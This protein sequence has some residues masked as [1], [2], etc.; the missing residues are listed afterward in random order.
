MVIPQ[1]LLL[2]IGA[3]IIFSVVIHAV[4]KKRILID[5]SLFWVALAIILVLLSIFPHIVYFFA[6]LFNF[7][8]PSN[9]VFATI[10]ALLLIKEFRNTAKIS[11]LKDRVNQLTQELALISAKKD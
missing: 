6:H 9:L 8:S 4:H 10:I 2:L 5:D 11:I 1:K 3:V 7:Q